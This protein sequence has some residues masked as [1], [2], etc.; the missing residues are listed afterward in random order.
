[1]IQ[2]ILDEPALLFSRFRSATPVPVLERYCNT[3]PL[4]C[5]T[6]TFFLKVFAYFEVQLLY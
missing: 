4:K 3:L 2:M 1:M 5:Y 6:I